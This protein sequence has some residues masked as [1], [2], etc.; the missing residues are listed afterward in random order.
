MEQQQQNENLQAPGTANEYVLLAQVQAIRAQMEQLI[1]ANAELAAQIAAQPESEPEAPAHVGSHN[2]TARI[3][4]PGKF[5]GIADKRTTPR[6]WL[7]L[8]RCYLEG[9]SALYL[10]RGVYLLLPLLEGAAADWL[11]AR[12]RLRGSNYEEPEDLLEDIDRWCNP[13]YV[14][15]QLRDKLVKI[16]QTGSVSDYVNEFEIIA[17]QILDM[18]ANE[19]F[20][21]F[22]EGLNDKPRRKVHEAFVTQYDQAVRIAVLEDRFFK[23]VDRREY[24]QPAANHQ[25]IAPAQPQSDHMEVDNVGATL[26]PGPGGRYM[27]LTDAQRTYLMDH[28]GCFKCRKINVNHTQADCKIVFPPRGGRRAVANQI[29]RDD[30][31]ERYVT[32]VANKLAPVKTALVSDL[33]NISITSLKLKLQRKTQTHTIPL[34]GKNPD[35]KFVFEA[36]VDGI[37]CTALLDSGCTAMIMSSAF[38]NEMGFKTF[39]ARP[40]SFVFANSARDKSALATT[41]RFKCAMYERIM[42]F[43]VAPIKEHLILGTPFWESMVSVVD[44]G[45]KRIELTDTSRDGAKYTWR[46]VGHVGE[47]TVESIDSVL[48]DCEWFTAIDVQQMDT[49]ITLQAQVDAILSDE[50]VGMYE[51]SP[52]AS[53][54]ATNLL[55]QDRFKALLGKYKTMFDTPTGL[56]PD[57]PETHQIKLVNDAVPSW[58][59]LQQLNK[60]ELDTLKEMLKDQTAKGFISS[61]KS[62]YGASIIFAKKKGGDLRLCIDYR[63]LND[64]TVK[65]RT[66]LPNI[67]EMRDR[68]A[69]AK[70]FS[71]LD[72]R[73]GF[74]NILVAPEDRHKT[75]FRTRYGHFEYNVLPFGLC[76]APA[77]F[78]GMMNRIFGDLYDDFLEVFVD[79]LLVFSETEEEHFAHLEEIFKRITAN[80]LFVKESKCEFGVE[81][82]EFCGAEVSR[83]GI[84][85][86]RNKLAPL[87]ATK[88]PRNVKDVQSFMGAANWFR[89]FVESFSE[90]ATPLTEL[91]KKATSWQ[92]TELEQST[93]V[94]LLHRISTAPCLRYFDPSLPTTVFTDASLFG[95]GGWIGQTHADGIHPVTFWSRKL[96]PAELN[97][98]THERELLALVKMCEKHRHYLIG[99]PFVA[100][101]DHRALIHLQKQPNLSS[102]QVNW[103]SKLQDYDIHIEY[104]PGQLNNLADLLSRS[105]D[106]VPR[107]QV[108]KVNRAVVSEEAVTWK[109]EDNGPGVALV[110]ELE[111]AK[112]MD[113]SPKI[114]RGGFSMAQCGLTRSRHTKCGSMPLTTDKRPPDHPRPFAGESGPPV[115]HITAPCRKG[116]TQAN[117][118]LASAGVI[119]CGGARYTTSSLAE[120][121]KQT[122][123]DV[124]V[125]KN[126]REQQLENNEVALINI[127]VVSGSTKKTKTDELRPDSNLG[128][129]PRKEGDFPLDQA[130][131]ANMQQMIRLVTEDQKP[132]DAYINGKIRKNWIVRDGLLWYGE[133]RLYVPS[134]DLRLS[135][136]R[137]FHDLPSA[138]HQGSRR[139]L[140]KIC[141]DYFWPSIREDTIR[142]VTSCDS[143]QRHKPRNAQPQ[144]L[145]SPLP[146]PDER[147]DTISIDFMTLPLSK[148]GFNSCFVIVDKLTKLISLT[149]TKDTSSASDTAKIFV[150]KWFLSGRGLPKSII[151][152]RDTRFVS[153][154]WRG[155]MKN[156][157]IELQLTTARHQQANGQAENIVKLTKDTLR[158]FVGYNGKDW[159]TFLPYVEFALNDS[160]SSATGFSPFQLAF[161]L[162]GK[163]L[164][165][166]LSKH[167]D[168]TLD[169]NIDLAKLKIAT[170][171]D[172]MIVNADRDRQP[173]RAYITGDRV[174]LERD[175][176]NWPSDSNT[177]VKLLSRRLGPFVILAFDSK[178]NN[179]TLQL[180]VNLKIHPVFHTSLVSPYRDPA[181]NFP[182]RIVSPPVGE[183]FDPDAEFEVDKIVD[184]RMYRKKKQV[185]IRWKGYGAEH[186]WWS[187]LTD[188]SCP[189]EIRSYVE[190]RGSVTIDELFT[191]A[192]HVISRDRS[193][194]SQLRSTRKRASK[195]LP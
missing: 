84:N 117:G 150:Q 30:G 81:R 128:L 66:P 22:M 95:I 56:P 10:R 102:R 28:Q 24:R 37:R 112:T 166:S 130:G 76:N 176:I 97:Y 59:P 98:P 9:N 3:P 145:L 107:C 71:K 67:N 79:D 46:G 131:H 134:K 32:L 34:L 43:Y 108:C 39:P 72:L 146:I 8:A 44:W 70:Y 29:D 83:E 123:R 38:V 135:I 110:A 133:D 51:F 25:R 53:P 14:V 16:R 87:F 65:D 155:I 48:E 11:L 175:G 163:S 153:S 152:D 27:K 139:T 61:S 2:P 68:L 116:V 144:G 78:M 23:Q 52:P 195:Q 104:I 148:D 7:F 6:A 19:R 149:A 172:R 171:Q 26:H 180:P 94:L 119:S 129:L 106:F 21:R 73:D 18:D 63:G 141:R 154:F 193:G 89:D 101:T 54:P 177:D 96:I 13:P 41:V 90:I 17:M 165:S 142:Y 182:L 55:Q 80:K 161:G 194:D 33:S 113:A 69:K 126:E 12:V 4:S 31:D 118:S 188:T 189:E 179:V 47:E 151:S 162:N 164:S 5:S 190:N 111:S 45:K 105:P 167:L 91:T 140:E 57:R 137:Q 185:L 121:I 114:R 127:A 169:T 35:S 85:L 103:V 147:F 88:Q 158:A 77:T 160:V 184:H 138:G 173:A 58:R 1:L 62:P 74:H 93:V 125:R 15:A 157:G 156:L 82:T 50:R 75:A 174:M 64:D 192:K 122:R 186:D 183:P 49:D 136:L 191:R 99:Q 40:C 109:G 86:A 187:D 60:H 124:G 181:A 178:R 92:W 170:Q 20:H 42:T 168:E 143:C 132:P 159:T 115:E 120:T 36:T 100:K